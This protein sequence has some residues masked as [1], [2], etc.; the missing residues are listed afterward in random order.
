MIVAPSILA[1]DKNHLFEEASKMV[2]L[3]VK[4]IHIDIM[5]GK[6]VKNT[7]WD[8]KV[9]S[10]LKGIDAVLD[11]HLMVVDPYKKIDSFAKAGSNVIT[12]HYEAFDNDEDLIKTLKYIASKGITPGLSIK[13]KTEASAIEPFLPY[14]GLVLVMSV[15]PGEGGQ[16]FM[17]DALDKIAF[18]KKKKEELHLDYLIE[19]D[20]GINLET[21]TLC[22]KE[23]ADI[24]V[25]GTYF[26]GH[27]DYKERVRGMTAL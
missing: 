18:F 26:F 20:G 27:E 3:G 11:T 2:D 7:T 1:A 16:S 24:R 8:S 15:E 4:F 12:V 14:V 25:S 6:F 19:V 23:G 22:A 13:P 21:G 10:S 17:M 5:D 9:V